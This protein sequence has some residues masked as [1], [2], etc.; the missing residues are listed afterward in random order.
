MLHLTASVFLSN[1]CHACVKGYYLYGLVF[2]ILFITS[3]INHST[4]EEHKNKKIY[5]LIDKIFVW[6]V[7][8]VG[9]IY[10]L[11]ISFPQNILPLVSVGVVGILW[12]KIKY[13]EEFHDYD[14]NHC[15]KL[16]IILHLFSSIGHNAIMYAL[17]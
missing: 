16:H 9:F 7:I 3:Y 12:Y 13:T 15:R 8:S 2:F 4:P 14:I 6:I 5:N 1:V 11:E 10:L 17:V